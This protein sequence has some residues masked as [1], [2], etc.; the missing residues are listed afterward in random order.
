MVMPS[1]ELPAAARKSLESIG[2]RLADVADG[3]PW[4][5]VAPELR[6]L[7]A[8]ALYHASRA[9][10]PGLEAADRPA[11][12]LVGV[13]AANVRALRLEAG[14]T[15]GQVAE[16]MTRA[17]FDWKRITVAEVEA[18]GR[19]VQLDEMLTLAAL[20]GV[21][22]VSLLMP[23]E[24]QAVVIKDG[25]FLAADVVHEL[26]L[27]DG[28]HVG[29]GGPDWQVAEHATG[30]LGRARPAGDYWRHAW[31]DQGVRR[32]RREDS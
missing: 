22:M 1:E 30:T 23:D 8:N 20:F 4:D 24:D 3:D 6:D 11:V 14:W 13:V 7:L 15:Q 29:D 27:G 25:R 18:G 32:R 12:D 9:R 16:V 26:V 28:G 17:G 10:E 21:P 5:E 31:L 19:R 2:Q